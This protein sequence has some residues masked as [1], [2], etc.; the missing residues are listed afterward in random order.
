MLPKLGRLRVKGSHQRLLDRQSE[1]RIGTVATA[2]KDAADRFF[3]SLQLGSDT[4]FVSKLNRAN[5]QIGIDLNTENFLT[6]SDGQTIANPRY[7]RTIKGKLA[8]AQRILSRRQRSG[9]R[10]NS[11]LCEKV[12]TIRSNVR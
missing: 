8:K 2:T 9:L 7:Y 6:A 1:I 3:V 10:K 12:K 5:R 4:P 11:V